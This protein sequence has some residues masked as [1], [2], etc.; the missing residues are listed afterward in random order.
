MDFRPEVNPAE[1]MSGAVDGAIS[2]R[3]GEDIQKIAT[4]MAAVIIS[5]GHWCSAEEHD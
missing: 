1:G 5:G 4:R 2:A 3:D